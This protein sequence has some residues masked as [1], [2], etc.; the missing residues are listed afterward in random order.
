[1]LI[2]EYAILYV[3]FIFGALLFK[4]KVTQKL[5]LTIIF[6]I[7]VLIVGFRPDTLRD[8]SEYQKYFLGQETERLE[9]GFM[10]VIDFLRGK[11]NDTVYYFLLFA[12]FSVGLRFWFLQK[13][14]SFFFLSLIIYMS[15]IF[16]LHDMIQIR[17]AMASV[18]LLWSTIYIYE[19][20]IIPCICIV[21]LGSL[22]HYSSL[23]ILPLYFFN[24]R[25]ALW[26]YLILPF[27][28]VCYFLSLRVGTLIQHIP[29][30]F[31]QNLYE[32]YS[33][34]AIFEEETVN[35]FSLL[36]VYR[37]LLFLF[38][39]IWINKIK[40][41]NIY[42]MLY[43]KIYA[44]SLASLVLFS[45]IPVVAFRISELLQVV[46]IVLLPLLVYIFTPR[47]LGKLVVIFVSM[48]IVIINIFYIQLLP[49]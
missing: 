2:I 18:A 47:Y 34:S 30:D 31:I 49:C 35:V 48:I 20:K 38:L 40:G 8:Y 46:E 4:D 15:N 32:M 22:F 12:L 7:L 26:L 43:L 23:I 29:I 45:D 44:L 13:Y 3:S 16:I 36:H 19:K 28:Y 17:A 5:L 1:M 9:I 27:S 41:K 6:V 14:A 39:L 10:F 21:L 42:A 24:S 37:C 11:L 25:K 33:Q